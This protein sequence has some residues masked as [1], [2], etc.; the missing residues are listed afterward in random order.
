MVW[1]V[2]TVQWNARDYAAHSQ[3]QYR[4]GIGVVERLALN[5]TEWVLDIGCGDGK[6]TVELA[7]QVAQGRVLGVDNAA[8]MIL[9]ARS[10]HMPQVPNVDFMLADAQTLHLAPDFDLAFSN[11]SGSLRDC[12]GRRHP[13]ADGQPG[14]GGR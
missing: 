1:I 5:G 8:D 4:W 6:L 14:G 7:R 13:A 3:G 12:R 2:S 11:S 10:T 9:F